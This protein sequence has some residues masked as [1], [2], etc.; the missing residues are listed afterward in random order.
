MR[1]C[2]PD[3]TDLL[4]DQ[5]VALWNEYVRAS[6]NFL[7]SEDVEKLTPF[8]KIGLSYIETLVVKYDIDMPIAFM[9]I[10]GRK[11]EMLFVLPNYL[12]NGIGKEL[13]AY[14]IENYNVKDVDV[15][16]QNPEAGGFYKH[17]VFATVERTELG[18]Q[19]NTFPRLKLKLD[20]I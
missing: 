5:L 17:H 6:H 2:N 15:N 9:G 10:D 13:V 16:E 1:R 11:I 18:E 7:T 12:G 20:K 14:A 4:I 19:G 8:V 3:R